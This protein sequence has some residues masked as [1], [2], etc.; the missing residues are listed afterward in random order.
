MSLGHELA[1]FFA[2]LAAGET[3]VHWWMGIWG[4]N[5]LPIEVGAFTFTKGANMVAM[6][7]WPILLAALAYYGW[8]RHSRSRAAASPPAPSVTA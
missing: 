2:G 4:A 8:F 1:K 6:I 7:A 5:L 3:I